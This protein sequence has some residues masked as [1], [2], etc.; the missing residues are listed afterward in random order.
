MP[1]PSP[2]TYPST[3]VK[4]ADFDQFWTAVLAEADRLPLAPTFEPVPLRSTP[5]VDVF[6]VRFTSLDGLRIAAWYCRPA[7]R[8][9]PLPG[10][11][12]VP[13]YVSEP[14]LP[15]LWAERGYATLSLAPRGK[16]RSNARFNPGYPGLL[17]HNI[18][19]R[20]TY[21]YRGFYADAYRAVDVL[22]SRAEVDR[23]RIG[24]HGSSQGGALTVLIS[25]LRRE[26]TCGAAGAP[27]LCGF[28]D[29]AA[30]TH[31]YP[32][33]EINDYL[34]LY[35]ER[36]EAVRATLNYYD[37]I[38]FADRITCPML[39]NIGLE[40]D[41]CP[42][43]TGYALVRAMTNARVDLHVYPNCAHDAG[44]AF[45]ARLVADFLATHLQSN[46]Q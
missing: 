29:A 25:S 16:L 6:D 7:G 4:P 34:R 12:I 18:V 5:Q 3:T 2:E 26:I 41:V 42:P 44:S 36:A 33:Q 35:P 22:L 10:L 40:D 30:L 19:D 20:N 45:H 27:Y 17:T 39:I 32:Y 14:L 23:G 43:E 38:N 13:G 1:R 24:V 15:K 11:I 9:G 21:G 31:S 8:R 37:I 28:M 46:E